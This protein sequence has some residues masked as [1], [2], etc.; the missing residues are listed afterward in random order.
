MGLKMKRISETEYSIVLPTLF[1]PHI[2][3]VT[4]SGYVSGTGF[5]HDIALIIP[6]SRIVELNKNM[7]EKVELY[8][9]EAVG[10]K[11]LYIKIYE[12]IKFLR[13]SFSIN[14]YKLVHGKME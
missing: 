1:Y 5:S 14:I 2:F 3:K 13:H 9:M 10:R 12:P 7:T 6:Y 4:F 8:D 11:M